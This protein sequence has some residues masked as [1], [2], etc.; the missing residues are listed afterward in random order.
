MIRIIASD[1]LYQKSDCHSRTVA[2]ALKTELVV[3]ATGY[4]LLNHEN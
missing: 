1:R 2:I 4:F 3:F